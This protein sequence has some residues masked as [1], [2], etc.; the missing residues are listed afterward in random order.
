MK[1]K[2]NA[3]DRTS[4]RQPITSNALRN[5]GLIGAV[6]LSG[7]LLACDGSGVTDV[8]AAL[9]APTRVQTK[10]VAEPHFIF[11]QFDHAVVN[12]HRAAHDSDLPDL[13]GASIAE[14]AK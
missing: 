3:A 7:L 2:P 10:K 8:R 9:A 6:I 13:Q 1:T 12:Q 11:E 14:Y 5:G 4:Q